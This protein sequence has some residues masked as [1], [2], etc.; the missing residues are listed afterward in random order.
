MYLLCEEVRRYLDEIAVTGLPTEVIG[1]TGGGRF[2]DLELMA[3]V[4]LYLERGFRVLVLSNAMRPMMKGAESLLV[5]GS[6]YC[7]RLTIRMSIDHYTEALHETE[8]GKRS[9]QRAVEGLLWLYSYGFNVHVAGNHHGGI[10]RPESTGQHRSIWRRRRPPWAARAA[11]DPGDRP[12]PRH[13]RGSS[14]ALPRRL[15]IRASF[16]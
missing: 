11:A 13:A 3:M 15:R 1:I 8:C 5:L 6:R 14:P 2:M 9:W 4:E 7:D 10:N 12:R 16:L